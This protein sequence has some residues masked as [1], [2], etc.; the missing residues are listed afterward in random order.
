MTNKPTTVQELIDILKTFPP[1]MPVLVSGYE[2]GY[3]CFY[4]PYV[5]D[6]VH[7]PDNMYFDGEYQHPSEG[8]IP[9]LTALIL[10]R[11]NRDD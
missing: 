7:Q 4:D 9:E 6:L 11:M 8:E 10:G 2:T 1:D 3:E 5:A